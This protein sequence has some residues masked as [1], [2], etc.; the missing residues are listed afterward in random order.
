LY[1]LLDAHIRKQPSEQFDYAHDFSD[2]LDSAETI[3]L[4]SV[5]VTDL[6]TGEDAAAAILGSGAKAPVVSGS[7]VR[8]WLVPSAADGDYKISTKVTTSSDRKHEIDQIAH[9]HEV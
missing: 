1:K 6:A 7:E 5:A 4:D 8:F 2:A 3:A 9:I